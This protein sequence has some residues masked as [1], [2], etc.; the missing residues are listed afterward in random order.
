MAMRSSFIL[1]TESQT[2]I[3]SS[4]CTFPAAVNEMCRR[5]KYFLALCAVVAS[6][7]ESLDALAANSKSKRTLA[8][9]EFFTEPIL[10]TF[11]IQLSDAAIAQLRASPRSYVTGT[12]TE[13]ARVLANVA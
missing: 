8:S 3:A 1:E 5:A 10:R 6:T 12:I 13:G 7:F 2:E 4:R 11:E 9:D